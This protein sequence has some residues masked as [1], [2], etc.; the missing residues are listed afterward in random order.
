MR[1]TLYENSGL[2]QAEGAQRRAGL[3]PREVR[4]APGEDEYADDEHD[5]AEGCCGHRCHGCRS[6]SL[7]SETCSPYRP[8]EPSSFPQTGQRPAM[9]R[10]TARAASTITNVRL[11]SSTNWNSPKPATPIR[12]RSATY[13]LRQRLTSARDRPLTLP[14]RPCPIR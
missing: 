12:F 13:E 11:F 10:A 14:P 4:E 8:R 9:P 6:R 5:G 1:S 7:R 2:V 3:P